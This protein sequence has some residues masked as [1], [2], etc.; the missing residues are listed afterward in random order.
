MSQLICVLVETVL[1]SFGSSRFGEN[2]FSN[3]SLRNGLDL[4]LS[5]KGEKNQTGVLLPPLSQ[6]SYTLSLSS[7][8]HF[9]FPNS[10]DGYLHPM[11]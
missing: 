7:S 9:P 5:G 2:H 1:F 8:V 3:R 11:L 10:I 6:A 4:Y